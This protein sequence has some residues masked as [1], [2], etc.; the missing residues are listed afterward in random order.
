MSSAQALTIAVSSLG[1]LSS[2]SLRK[3]SI[4][5]AN[6]VPDAG[7]PCNTPLKTLYKVCFVTKHAASAV[8]HVEAFDQSNE[9][10]G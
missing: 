4:T 10:Y 1:S 5:N 9:P 3:E 2:N 8:E 6:N 7:Q